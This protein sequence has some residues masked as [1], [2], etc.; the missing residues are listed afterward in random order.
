MSN[1]FNINDCVCI[2]NNKNKI[3]SVVSYTDMETKHITFS[4]HEIFIKCVSEEYI[5][6]YNL[7]LISNENEEEWTAALE[8]ELVLCKPPIIVYKFDDAPEILKKLSLHGGDEDW[9]FEIPYYLIKEDQDNMLLNWINNL[10]YETSTYPH[11][12]K[13]GWEVRI[14]SH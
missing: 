2:N 14:I 4:D 10:S 13:S 8:F 1:K 3:Y 7:K 6:L 9:L 12:T 11:P 5:K